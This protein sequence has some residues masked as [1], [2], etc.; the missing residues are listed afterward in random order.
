MDAAIKS[1]I[2]GLGPA[3]SQ[4]ESNFVFIMNPGVSMAQGLA[5]LPDTTP[6]A[7]PQQLYIQW[8]LRWQRRWST[9]AQ[10]FPAGRVFGSDPASGWTNVSGDATLDISLPLLGEVYH[11]NLVYF[12]SAEETRLSGT[13]TASMPLAGITGTVTVASGSPLI[14]KTATG[15]PGAVSN[16]C[17]YSLS[18]SVQVE[19]QGPT[20]TMRSTWVFSPNK[21]SADVQGASFADSSGKTRCHAGFKPGLAMRR[22]VA[23]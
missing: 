8:S 20:G 14:V 19:V 11:G 21:S 4:I 16:A 18:G 13:G 12:A 3:I 15:A 6:G 23:A 7:A 5:L 2:A 1:Q 17:G 9:R 22:G 10:R